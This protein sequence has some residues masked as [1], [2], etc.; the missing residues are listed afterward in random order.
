MDEQFIIEEEVILQGVVGPEGVE[1]VLEE[2]DYY[3]ES[4]SE[5]DVGPPGP[6]GVAESPE[7]PPLSPASVEA[8]PPPV[9]PLS[10]VPAPSPSPPAAPSPPGPPSPPVMGVVDPEEVHF[11]GVLQRRHVEALEAWR[12]SVLAFR[13]SPAFIVPP[14]P[15]PFAGPE[16]SLFPV[17]RDVGGACSVGGG[18][19]GV[20]PTPLL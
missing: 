13:S 16:D 10:P 6:S 8:S 18:R 7:S 2:E 5:E 15:L 14:S 3:E 12:G 1:V 9:G 20:S 19:C 17:G 11:L 4:S